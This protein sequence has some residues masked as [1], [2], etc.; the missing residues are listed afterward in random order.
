MIKILRGCVTLCTIV[1]NIRKTTDRRKALLENQRYVFKHNVACLL[2]KVRSCM[3]SAANGRYFVCFLRS[4]L[5]D[6][7]NTMLRIRRI[8]KQ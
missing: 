1:Q 6:N 8:K 4:M 7:P 5:K 2:F 3:R